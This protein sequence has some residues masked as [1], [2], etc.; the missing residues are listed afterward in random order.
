MIAR[1]WP[2]A[3]AAS[4]LTLAGAVRAQ[5]DTFSV[6]AQ[7]RGVVKKGFQ[8][9]GSGQLNYSGT[10]AN[11]RITGSAEVNHPK[12]KG[13]VYQLTIDM[14]FQMGGGQIRYSSNRNRCNRGSEEALRKVEQVLPFVYLVKN[15]QID[16]GTGASYVTPRGSFNLRSTNTQRNLEVTLDQGDAMVGKFFMAPGGRQLEKFRIP[17]GEDVVLSFVVNR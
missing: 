16:E 3:L 8:S 6:N 17:A 11:F 7:Y 2:L 14:S 4:L 12:Q 9:I 5:T 15:G 10:P 1:A 13:R